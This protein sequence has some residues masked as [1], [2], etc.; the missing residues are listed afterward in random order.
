VLSV[1]P[2]GGALAREP[3]WECGKIGASKAEEANPMLPPTLSGATRLVPILAHPVDHVRAPRTYNPAFA[4]AGLDWCQVPMGVHPDHLADVISQL[5]RVSNLQ[6]INLTIPH[7]PQAFQLCKWLTR[8][9]ARV[10]MVNTMRLEPDGSWAGTNSDGAGF[11][12]AARE[13]RVL[14]TVRPVAIVGAGGAGT[15]IAFALADEGVREIHVFDIDAA[16]AAQ[17][18]NSLRATFPGIEATTQPDALARAGLAVNATPLGLHPGQD[19]PFDPARLR[20]DAAVFDI[21]AARDTEL[22][23]A[24]KTRGLRA[25]G[26]RPMVEHQLGTQIAFWRGDSIA[27][28]PHA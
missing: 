14:D 11:I 5:A 12:G 20:D 21:N 18:A 27:L 1:G 9:A 24:A 7:K 17:L 26:G 4:A 6:G 25:I 23:A 8:L 28:E 19:L 16:R 22:V 15:A 13:H 10:R 3:L 2:A